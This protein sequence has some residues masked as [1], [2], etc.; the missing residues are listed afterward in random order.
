[1]NLDNKADWRYGKGKKASDRPP[2]GVDDAI[3]IDPSSR[4]FRDSHGKVVPLFSVIFHFYA[5]A[6]GIF[7]ALSF[8]PRLQQT[9]SYDMLFNDP[10]HTF[11]V[12]CPNWGSS[13]NPGVYDMCPHPARTPNNGNLVGYDEYHGGPGY[14]KFLTFHQNFTYD[15]VNR[16]RSVADSG[17]WSRTFNYDAF[18]NMWVSNV[19]GLATGAYT[20]GSVYDANNRIA[21]TPYDPT[22]NLLLVNANTLTYDAENRQT[23]VTAPAA[24]AGGT[25]QY[26]YD[27]NGRRVAKSGPSGAT[28]YVY[29]A[30]GQL[31]AEY[32]TVA[33]SS[34]CAT[35]YLHTDHLGT[36]RLITDQNGN[37]VSRHDFAPFG[38]EIPANQVGRDAHFGPYNDTVNQQFTA[39]ERDPE[40]GL[41][42]FGARYY[43][44]ALG[45]FTSPDEPFESQRYENP[46]TLNLYA[47]VRNNPLALTDP[48][49][50]RYQVCI[51]NQTGGQSCVTL[52]DDQYQSLYNKQNGQQGIGLPG[53]PSGG[54]ITCGGSTCGSVSYTEDSLQNESASIGFG[55]FG[56]KVAE[57]VIGK[58]SSEI[59]G[60]FGKTAV[61]TTTGRAASGFGDLTSQEVVQI[62]KV[63]NESGRPI[64]VVGSA[65]KGTRRAVG[66][67]LP[68]GKGP[69]TQSDIDYIA[70]PSSHPYVQPYQDQLPGLDPGHGIIPGAQNPYVGPAIRFEP[71]AAP[72]YIPMTSTTK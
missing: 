37:V 30:A 68:V 1:M 27:G 10:N 5:Q 29:D 23:T 12:S 20:S 6:N 67:D 28:V 47:Y 48:D 69:G 54:N 62:Q 43:G 21:N 18:G 11:F 19:A 4:Q 57:A 65:A 38:E 22:G 51:N 3:G 2:A 26:A 39:K 35:C 45:R 9:E 55:I 25:E 14:P 32:P 40:S 50:H 70:P 46:Q 13:E 8:N 71:G 59:A 66:S 15:G 34:P 56:G 64:E 60:I 17:G 44:S 36:T 42:Y 16:L 49:G 61:E 41:D 24:F 63:V 53:G 7:H 72:Q 31:A 33:A 58:V 52:N